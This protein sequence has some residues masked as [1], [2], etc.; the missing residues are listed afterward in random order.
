VARAV[1]RP[2]RHR[3]GSLGLAAAGIAA[4]LL[5]GEGLVR[6]VSPIGPALLVT[7]PVVGKRFTPGFRGRVFVDEAGREVDL[8][9]N[10]DGFPGPDRT[11]AKA[12]G[13]LRVAVI[14][15]SMTAAVATEQSRRFVARLEEALAGA[16]PG[17][18]VEV[19]NFGVSS[20]STGSE[21]VTW[22]TVVS[23]YAPDVVLLAFFTG[24]DLGDNSVRLT[25]A[26]RVYFDVDASGRLVAGEMPSPTP[27][28]TRWLDRH[29]R[30]YVWQK[31]A[32]RRLRAS[33]RASGIEPGQ[34]AFARDGGPDVEHA[35]ALTAA[36]LRAFRD[37]VEATGAR[38]ALAVIP[39]AEQVDDA[40]WAELARRAAEAGL[41]VDREEPS[42]RLGAVASRL[43]I[44][45]ADL[46][47]A[48]AAAARRTPGGPSSAEALFL[49][50]R[51]HLSDEGHRVAA[52]AL[53]RFFTEGDGRAL[54]PAR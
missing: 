29:S 52:A 22:R 32:T 36:L 5:L 45:V 49:L 25:R 3:A 17:R 38:F 8:F 13:L 34:L 31:V 40:L 18:P 44:P 19:L 39:C 11:R 14:G 50:G 1:R 46:T 16:L 42:R 7:D 12:K 21:L 2:G 26:P 41:C 33:A 6:F 53:A 10:A 30:L 23:A 15:D 47:P 37:E 20:A 9:I 43:G 27:A 24:N 48:F 28:L 51:F 35:W 4:A 54:L